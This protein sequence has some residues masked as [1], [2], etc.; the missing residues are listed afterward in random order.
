MA[1]IKIIPNKFKSFQIIAATSLVLMMVSCKADP[2]KLLQEGITYRKNGQ[3]EKARK[4]I[5]K[6][7]KIEKNHIAYKELGNYYLEYKED[8]DKAIE[9]YQESLFQHEDYINAIHNIGLAYLKKFE[10]SRTNK[11]TD[12]SH[13]D[14]AQEWLN[15]ALAIDNDYTLSVSEKGKLLFYKKEYDESLETLE[16]ALNL[17]GADEGYIRTIM[18]QVYL[19][20]LKQYQKA[21]DNFK[22]SYAKYRKNPD[23]VYYMALTHRHLNNRIE[24]KTYY[25]KYIDLLKELKSP[26]DVLEN[27]EKQREDFFAG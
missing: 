16:R 12:T 20:G 15:K 13:L 8:Y 27:A 26:T 2:D 6:V 10:L 7:L 9:L 5:E 17:S 3:Y 25:S 21:L 11:K 14:K 18:G 23:L 4:K 1:S 24:A 19:R 22:V